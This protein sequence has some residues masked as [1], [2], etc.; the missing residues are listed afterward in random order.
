[1]KKSIVIL[2]AFAM[3]SSFAACGKKDDKNKEY[4]IIYDN[5]AGS[6]CDSYSG[7]ATMDLTSTEGGVQALV[8]WASSASEH[9]AWEFTLTAGEG[10]TFNY[11]NG[12]HMRITT[13]S[14]DKDETEVLAEN[15]K[16]FMRL[17]GKGDLLWNG[18]PDED[19]RDCVFEKIE[20]Q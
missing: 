11:S 19:C 9:D 17:N 1:M 20:I 16:G 5:L 6:Y 13:L 18:A 4:Q 12:V 7:R 15:E 8:S 2:L 3:I 10:D 14:E